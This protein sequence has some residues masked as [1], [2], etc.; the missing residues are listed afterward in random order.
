[1]HRLAKRQPEALILTR[2]FAK[3]PS[4]PSNSQ[5]AALGKAR[6]ILETKREPKREL[7]RT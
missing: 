4:F 7:L 6:V 3:K 1:M 5:I 2:T